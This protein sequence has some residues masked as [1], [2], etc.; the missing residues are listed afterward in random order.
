MM[1]ARSGPSGPRVRHRQPP[2]P[3]SSERRTASPLQTP[4]GGPSGG[5]RER[6]A[7][8]VPDEHP[9]STSTSLGRRS[10]SGADFLGNEPAES[11]VVVISTRLSLHSHLSHDSLS[12]GHGSRWDPVFRKWTL[13]LVLRAYRSWR[14][15]SHIRRTHR[16]QS[17]GVILL[18]DFLHVGR[19]RRSARG[20][21]LPTRQ[22]RAGGR[23]APRQ[24]CTLP[25]HAG[26]P[27]MAPVDDENESL[28]HAP[29]FHAGT[30][31]RTL[32]QRPGTPLQRPRTNSRRPHEPRRPRTKQGR[33]EARN[34]RA[35]PIR[36]RPRAA[37][38]RRPEN[39][40]ARAPSLAQRT[41]SVP[42]RRASGGAAPSARKRGAGLHRA[43]MR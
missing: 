26:R 25:I 17:Q 33:R 2:P 29:R 22:T 3:R 14:K 43:L 32:V 10:L 19:S 40:S 20:A 34:G 18:H 9:R 24:L 23:L 28:T 13:T 30:H 5:A 38:G 12:S 11:V 41:S 16:I 31:G 7:R 36:A 1:C 21:W 6:L 27:L 8:P 37:A 39:P 42:W 15:S 35:P 4:R